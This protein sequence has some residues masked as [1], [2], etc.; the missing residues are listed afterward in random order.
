MPFNKKLHL[1]E[2][3]V[4]IQM[5]HKISAM[6]SGLE[7]GAFT[8]WLEI[9]FSSSYVKAIILHLFGQ[10]VFLIEY[11]SPPRLHDFAGNIL[12]CPP[13]YLYFL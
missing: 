4:A 12:F 13:L 10:C 2:T 1:S 5:I 11:V 6:L 9:S 3:T 7:Y 8:F